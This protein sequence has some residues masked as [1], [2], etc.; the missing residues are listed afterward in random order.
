MKKRKLA[1]FC[2]A[3]IV[4]LACA[5]VPDPS[6]SEP[7]RA[8]VLR[9]AH[10]RTAETVSLAPAPAEGAGVFP[11][12]HGDP[13]YGAGEP[14]D[15][16]AFPMLRLELRLLWAEAPHDAARFVNGEVFHAAAREEYVDRIVGTAR[17]LLAHRIAAGLP[18]GEG[19]WFH[20]ESAEIVSLSDGGGLIMRVEADSV[21]GGERSVRSRY[22]VFDLEARRRVEITDL[23][24]DFGG[25]VARAVV[26]A[27][28]R[29]Q[30]GIEDGGRLSAVGFLSDEPELSFNFWVR[31]D[32]LILRWNPGDIA[33]G[34]VDLL[35]P[36]RDVRPLLLPEGARSLAERFGI[37]VWML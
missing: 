35:L 4:A 28:L 9:L 32:G 16:A 11:I 31:S 20:G 17:G 7:D 14:A 2:L 10:W 37:P 12:D 33:E 30:A 27:A 1:A 36:W 8:P 22:H 6:H 29:R 19:D 34:S 13:P 5:A 3:P 21:F 25:D 18:L 15:A 26:L 24:D 23:I